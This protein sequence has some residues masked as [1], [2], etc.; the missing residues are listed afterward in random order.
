MT[1]TYRGYDLP[2]VH[3]D[4]PRGFFL[5]DE[6]FDWL[7]KGATR[8]HVINQWQRNVDSSLLKELE[9][10]GKVTWLYETRE[11]IQVYGC[12][13]CGSFVWEP[14]RHADTHTA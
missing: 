9:A 8:E 7:V 6:H 14:L 12:G 1:D 4:S 2:E 3:T 5:L 11:G 10:Q 13:E